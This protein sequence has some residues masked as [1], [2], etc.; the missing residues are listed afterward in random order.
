MFTLPWDRLTPTLTCPLFRPVLQEKTPLRAKRFPE[1]LLSVESEKQLRKEADAE[2][3]EGEKGAVSVLPSRGP[4]RRLCPHQTFMWVH[5]RQQPHRW[6]GPILK[7]SQPTHASA[8]TMAEQSSRP[9][10]PTWGPAVR[11]T[12]RF[13]TKKWAY[14]NQPLTRTPDH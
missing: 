9:S 7:T 6:E 14:Q 1:Q 13:S 3:R 11:T 12:P 4:S 8:A 5:P 10:V 2:G